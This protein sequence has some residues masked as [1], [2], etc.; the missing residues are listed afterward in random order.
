M[1]DLD[2]LHLLS[3]SVFKEKLPWNILVGVLGSEVDVFEVFLAEKGG[4]NTLGSEAYL[5]IHAVIDND[6]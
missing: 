5:K 6:M 1:S 3:A 2:D 4:S